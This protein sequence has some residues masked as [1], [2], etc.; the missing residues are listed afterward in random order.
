MTC[1]KRRAFTLIELLVVIAIIALLISILLPALANAREAANVAYCL[2][3]L[4]TQV[5]TAAIYIDDQQGD[6][7]MPWHMGFQ[8]GGQSASWASEYVYGGVQT[9]NQ[10]PDPQFANGDWHKWWT[11]WRPYNK[12]VAPGTTGKGANI[13]TWV[14][15]SDKK[16]LTPV[17]GQT[18]ADGSPPAYPSYVAVGNSYVIHWYWV[19]GPPWNDNSSYFTI[20]DNPLTYTGNTMTQAGRQLLKKKVGGPAAKF[21]LHSEGA[22]NAYTYDMVDPLSG[23]TSINT[24]PAE[25][26]HK[27]YNRFSL[28]FFDGHAEYIFADVRYA[29]SPIYDLWA[30]SNTPVQ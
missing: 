25:G 13:K 29:K 16:D 9:V 20:P 8:E 23:Q 4:K 24:N 26:W 18:G 11:E 28:G 7:A 14:C 15:P 12:Y 10:H 2:N 22:F 21:P 5:T 17:V 3:N 30:E 19:K 6:L 1:K 27:K